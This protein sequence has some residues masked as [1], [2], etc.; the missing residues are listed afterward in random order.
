MPARRSRRY[1]GVGELS[2]QES[3]RRQAARD[4]S[5]VNCSMSKPELELILAAL[6]AG[7]EA[8][9]E[10]IDR[11]E[12]DLEAYGSDAEGREY[13]E[14]AHRHMKTLDWFAGKLEGK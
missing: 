9:G 4:E 10:E 1:V 11:R 6:N 3:T 8:L 5:Q 13:I 12:H 7:G 2:P 14:A